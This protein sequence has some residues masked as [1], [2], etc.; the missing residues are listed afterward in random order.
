MPRP[1]DPGR[2]EGRR[3][4]DSSPGGGGDAEEGAP[5]ARALVGSS[6]DFR[7]AAVRPVSW[8]FREGRAE[9][10]DF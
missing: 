4:G 9:P 6:R 8:I 10:P 7:V 1:S 3:P 2:T 5:G